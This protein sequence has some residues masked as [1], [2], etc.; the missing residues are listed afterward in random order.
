MIK[1]NKRNGYGTH[2]FFYEYTPIVNVSIIRGENKNTGRV[3]KK[4]KQQDKER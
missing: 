4:E 3:I 1:K 2:C